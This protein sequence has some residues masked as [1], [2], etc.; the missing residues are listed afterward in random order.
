MPVINEIDIS[1]DNQIA[2]G[3]ELIENYSNK[4]LGFLGLSFKAGTDDLRNSPTVR[5]IETL[6]GKGAKISIYDSNINLTMLTGTNKDFID[7]RIPHLSKFLTLN[8]KEM[9]DEVDVLIVNTKEPEFS[10]ILLE[11]N[12][13]PIIDFVRINEEL[14][15]KDNYQGI[16]WSNISSEKIHH[17]S[18]EDTVL[19]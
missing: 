14:M 15:K 2:R 8:L 11:I 3:I 6:I 9:I 4:K 7:A 18:K 16:N 10:D 17:V 5:V 19:I 12:D 13:K 1:N